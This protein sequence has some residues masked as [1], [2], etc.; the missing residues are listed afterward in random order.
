M[1]YILLLNLAATWFMCGL[2]WFVQIVHYPLFIYADKSHWVVFHGAH[3]R[4]TTRVVAFPMLVELSTSLLLPLV[5]PGEA[6]LVWT[7]LAAN[8][9][10]WI[11][12]YL[13]QIPQ[14]HKILN[15]ELS[16]SRL[17]YSNWS[18]TLLWSLRSLLLLALV[19]RL[20]Q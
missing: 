8:L 20:L 19:I 12:T 13:V 11:L 1:I 15:A 18:R 9:F 10:I 14:H 16:I 4:K 17:V 3:Q 2:I 7:A 6:T 5:Y